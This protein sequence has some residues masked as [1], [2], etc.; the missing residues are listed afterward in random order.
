VAADAVTM[1]DLG[2]K[3]RVD[4]GGNCSP[5]ITIKMWRGPISIRDRSRRSGHDA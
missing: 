5:N 3:V 4:I 2:D 1:V